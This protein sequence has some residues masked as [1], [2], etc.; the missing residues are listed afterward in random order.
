[1]TVLRSPQDASAISATSQVSSTL[2]S[3]TLRLLMDANPGRLRVMAVDRP[4]LMPAA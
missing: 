4:P 3:R 2:G 1:M